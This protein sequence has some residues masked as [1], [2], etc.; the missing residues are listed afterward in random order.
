MSYNKKSFGESFCRFSRGGV[1]FGGLTLLLLIFV[2]YCVFSVTYKKYQ[3]IRIGM[4]SPVFL[5]CVIAGF[6]ALLL[7]CAIGRRLSPGVLFLLG[8]LFWLAAA[9]YILR[10]VKPE[11]IVD[12][13]WIYTGVEKMLAGDFSSFDPGTRPWRDVVGYFF[14]YPNNLGPAALELLLLSLWNSRYA[15]Y[16]FWFLCALLNEFLLW[17]LA[18]A[19]SDGDRAVENLTLL[20]GFVFLPDLILF[21]VIYGD[22]PGMTLLLAALLALFRYRKENKTRYAAVAV[23]LMTLATVIRVNLLIAAIAVAICLVLDGIQNK[24]AQSFLLAVMMLVLP[25]LGYNVMISA[26]ERFSGREIEGM[27]AILFTAMGLQDGERCAGW[28]NGWHN[29]AYAAADYDAALAKEAARA[30]ISERVKYFSANPSVACR[31]FGKKFVSTF[32]EPTYL[33]LVYSY[34]KNTSFTTRHVLSEPLISLFAHGKAARAYELLNGALAAL[35]A[36]FSGFR[37]FT[38]RKEE[39]GP[40]YLFPQLF[41]IGNALFYVFLWETKS[42]FVWP[43]MYMLIPSA[44]IGVR[45]CASLLKKKLRKTED[46]PGPQP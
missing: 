43:V 21:L 10:S 13:E 39:H 38:A 26:F 42:R 30:V 7:F 12:Q 35:I 23:L 8:S 24:R 20:I 6:F 31:F 46:V 17:R 36:F 27:P 1:T 14:T 18:R 16:A 44:A 33:S 4:Q 45:A 40:L 28:W 9:V 29:A 25:V 5:L 15:L 32:S 11:F 37:F 3:R 22:V 41:L 2:S 34:G 19:V